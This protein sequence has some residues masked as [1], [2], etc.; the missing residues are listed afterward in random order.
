MQRRALDPPPAIILPNTS[1]SRQ[2]G[3]EDGP[4]KYLPHAFRSLWLLECRVGNIV[5][6][7]ILFPTTVDQATKRNPKDRLQLQGHRKRK[8][9]TT[10]S[11]PER[12][13]RGK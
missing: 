11:V 2:R 5:D 12:K 13:M 1:V 9:A 10:L 7:L 8:S 3:V 4:R 6:R